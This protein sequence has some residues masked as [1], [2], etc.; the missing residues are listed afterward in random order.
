MIS[1][2]LWLLSNVWDDW[3]MKGFIRTSQWGRAIPSAYGSYSFTPSF[4]LLEWFGKLFLFSVKKMVGFIFWLDFLSLLT[5][6]C[7][8]IIILG[9]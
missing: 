9:F 3:C 7:M 6:C 5:F 1:E 2:F 8:P 4:L